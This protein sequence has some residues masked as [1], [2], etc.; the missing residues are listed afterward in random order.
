MILRVREVKTGF[1]NRGVSSVQ[2]H[3]IK[4]ISTPSPP[5]DHRKESRGNYNHQI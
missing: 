4:V 1:I 5:F 2:L 3:T